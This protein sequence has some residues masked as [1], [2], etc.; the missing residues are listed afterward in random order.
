MEPRH[1]PSAIRGSR[2]G[3]WG[4]TVEIHP[5]KT[6]APLLLTFTESSI[7]RRLFTQLAM[8]VVQPLG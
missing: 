8:I 2:G 6:D 1:L 7:N 5:N 3:R 4:D